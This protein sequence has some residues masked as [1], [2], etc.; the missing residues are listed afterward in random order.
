MR[1][2]PFDHDPQHAE[3]LKAV[4]LATASERARTEER[5]AR[6]TLLM[7]CEPYLEHGVA[8]M[9]LDDDGVARGYSLSCEDYEAWK[10]KFAPY[11]AQIEEMGQ[12]YRDRLVDE[13][14]YYETVYEKYPAH[15]HIDIEE[16]YTGGGNGRMLMLALLDKLRE[17]GVPAVSFGVASNNERA[18]G[19][20]EHMGFKRLTEYTDGIVFCM[21][22]GE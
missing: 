15:L 5:H 17:D 3:Q 14:N 7:Y 21:E 12:E 19:F 16:A 18:I 6:F 10:P 22:F 20:Y 4:C 11:R 2:V 9:L 8:F 1:V 13:L